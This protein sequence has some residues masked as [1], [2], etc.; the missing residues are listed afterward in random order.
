MGVIKLNKQKSFDMVW[1]YCLPTGKTR[2]IGAAGH[3]TLTEYMKKWET[4]FKKGSILEMVVE[5]GEMHF[6]LNSRPLGLAF[7]DE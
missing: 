6:I 5:K 4:K 7:K 3:T 2:W 1:S